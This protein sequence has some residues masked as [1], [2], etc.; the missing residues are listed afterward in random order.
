MRTIRNQLSNTLEQNQQLSKSLLWRFQRNF[1]DHQG[2]EAWNQGTVPHYIT[3]NPFIARAYAKVIFGFLRD[4]HAQGLNTEQPIYIMELGAGSGRFAYHFLKK[5]FEFFHRSP[6]QHISVKY[7]MTDFTDHNLE[8]WRSHPFLY[9][10][11]RSGVLD[12]ARFDME[13]D[14]QITLDRGGYI[15]SAATLKNPLI[16]LA[17]YVL[18]SIP[19]DAFSVRNRRLYESLVTLIPSQQTSALN[20]PKLINQVEINFEDHPISSNYYED[21]NF[22]KILEN[23]RQRLQDT[24]V[25]FPSVALK[26]I[27][28]LRYLSGDRLL[29]ISADKGHSHEQALLNRHHPSLT[30][31]GHC[32]S[33]MVNYHAIGRYFLQVGGQFL[34]VAHRHASLNICAFLLGFPFRDCVETRLAFTE[35]IEQLGPD[36]FFTLKKAIEKH[37]DTLTLPQILAL[38]RSS[39]WDANIFLG[40][41]PS[42]IQHL[43]T[44]SETLQQEL[45]QAIECIWDTYYPIGEQNDLAFHLARLLYK[46]TYYREASLYL[47]YS[48]MLYGA[49]AN[50]LYNLGKCYYRLGQLD[51]AIEQLDK[52]LEV[53]PS[54]EAARSMRKKIG[55]SMRLILV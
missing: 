27:R 13:R 6:L 32:F 49:S 55:D 47:Q 51:Q 37:Y 39:R 41:F 3:S 43:D 28:N 5:F 20:D 42:L 38:L 15:L 14:R 4:C 8:F 25:L 16:V 33:L 44:A 12:F 2:V 22:N 52:A 19:S 17:N 46:M 10:F 24:T 7:V 26:C 34:N 54:M 29:L 18:D 30:R 31:H 45:Y 36:D 9:P 11:V 1:F 23:Y 21:P 40:C 48:L 53:D 50:T 35:N